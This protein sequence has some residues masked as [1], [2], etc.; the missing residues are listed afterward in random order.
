VDQH[1]KKTENCCTSSQQYMVIIGLN[2]RE[3]H[4]RNMVSVV[5]APV[6]LHILSVLQT[7]HTNTHSFIT[8]L[9]TQKP[10]QKGNCCYL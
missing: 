9:L 3:M 6:D 8:S 5:A 4:C 2:V 7:Q 1:L 10:V